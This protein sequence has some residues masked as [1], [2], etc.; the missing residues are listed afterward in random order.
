MMETTTPGRTL[1]HGTVAV[2][3]G[4][5]AAWMQIQWYEP[6]AY[7]LTVVFTLAVFSLLVEIKAVRGDSDTAA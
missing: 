7:L 1:L 5:G 3:A 4:I 2:V 6:Q